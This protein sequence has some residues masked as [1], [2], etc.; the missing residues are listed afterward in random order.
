MHSIKTHIFFILIAVCL[1]LTALQIHAQPLARVG[2]TTIS[3][4]EFL[5]RYE[6]TPV[7]G[8]QKKSN[9]GE[10]KLKFLYTLIAEKLWSLQALEEKLDTTEAMRITYESFQK[11]FVRDLLYHKEI[12]E[13]VNITEQEILKGYA[14]NATK[15]Y[16][17]YLISEDKEEID[18]LYAF[19]SQGIPFDTILAE[20][21]ELAEQ[22]APLEIVYGQ[23]DE[24]IEDSLYKLKKGEYTYPIQTPDGWYIFRLTNRAESLLLEPNQEDESYRKAKQIVQARKE[25]VLYYQ[26]FGNYFRNIKV[27][28]DAELLKSLTII[29]SQIL[30]EKSVRYQTKQGD[31][32]YLEPL[33]VAKILDNYPA[34]T[35]KQTLIKFEKDPVDFRKYILMLGFDGFSVTDTSITSIFKK[36]N[37]RTR[38]FIEKELLSREGFKKG[39]QNDP[40][41]KASLKMWFD[42]YLFQM[43][44]SRFTDSVTVTDQEVQEFYKS[45]SKEYKFP[46]RLNIIEILTDSLEIV[47]QVL[48][49]VEKGTDFKSL[50]RLYNKREST[51]VKDGEYGFTPVSIL[52]ELGRVAS[53]M[54]IGEVYG[55]IKLPDGYSV[56]KLID[57]EIEKI[58]DSLQPFEKVKAK[59][60]S[61]LRFQK[62]KNNMISYTAGL[63]IKYGI[64]I[65]AD[66]LNSIQTT[67]VNSFGIRYM[68]FGGRITAA[69]LLPPQEDWIDEYFNRKNQLP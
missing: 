11:M 21:P 28:V 17:N 2:G 4:E 50:A 20:S 60:K 59:I 9:L 10:N 67:G 62:V 41:V 22:S 29:L 56:I 42:N 69:P 66:V 49:E 58:D 55:P 46:A 34:D 44:Q 18:N 39:Y 25:N 57:K 32:I 5:E 12:N 16:V 1:H 36:L 52:G 40:T 13:K 47:N 6:L 53:M 15:L 3:G 61:D 26:F 63:A 33:E 45:Y 51:K 8:K 38:S 31:K 65:N 48:A 23:M 35:L 7:F 30:S 24:S 37:S 19:L 27:D 54:A 14:R 64:N 68:G 43:L